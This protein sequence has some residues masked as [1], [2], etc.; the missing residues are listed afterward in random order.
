MKSGTADA[1][2][3]ST[4][5]DDA[6]GGEAQSGEA[7]PSRSRAAAEIA[8]AAPPATL[9]RSFAFGVLAMTPLF[10]VYECLQ[11][12]GDGVSRNTAEYVLTL[13]L[14]LFG[15]A[16]PNLR[17]GLLLVLVLVSAWRCFHS[18]LGLF[19]RVARVVLEGAVAA[20]I[21]GP[22]LLILERALALPLPPLAGSSAPALTDALHHASGAAFEEIVFRVG[23][24]SAFFVLLKEM[25]LFFTDQQLVSRV[26]AD[27][28]SI[29]LG[30]FVF[31]AAHLAPFVGLFGT[32]GEA[33]DG[34][35]FAWR[36]IAGL[37]LG[38]LFR[39]RGPG[40]AAWTHA[41]FNTA[42]FIGAGP[43]VFL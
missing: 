27:V 38:V 2:G 34:S 17:A 19:G 33:F 32:G 42:L 41:L 11:R 24:Q 43:D 26:A 13:P 25:F 35:V 5:H 28:T 40:V 22:L 4:V 10:V 9:Q 8:V 1:R 36:V 30:A 14:S 18:E 37:A 7:R 12:Y 6:R 16:A 39:V 23:L 15:A 21:L 31:A 29:A 3:R 20:V